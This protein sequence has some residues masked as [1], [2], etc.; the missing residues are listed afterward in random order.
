MP[1]SYPRIPYGMADFKAIRLQRRLYVDKT[2][3][4]RELENEDYVFLIRPRRF[5]KTYWL[6]LLE[7]YYDR[8]RADHFDNVFGGTDI[9]AR[10]TANRNRYVI[11]RFNFSAF[12]DAP[13]TLRERF[14]EHCGQVLYHA[15]GRNPDLFPEEAR[16][17][18]LAPPSI[19]GKLN[20]LFL[21]AGD[22]RIPLYV[23]I[24][25]YDNFA[26][27]VLAYHGE[28]SY[29]AF[30]HGGGFYRNFFAALKAGTEHSDGALERLFITGVSPIT[31]DDVTSGFNIG[32]NISLEPRFNELL[33]FT[34]REVRDLLDLHE[35]RESTRIGKSRWPGHPPP[36]RCVEGCYGAGSARGR[37]ACGG[38]PLGPLRALRQPVVS[39]RTAVSLRSLD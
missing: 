4:L 5:G 16:R 35:D 27:T 22:Q 11:L 36:C 34:E 12:D 31:L 8:N 24:D 26:N 6:S 20:R 18:I 7:H 38:R 10:P 13:E 33:G 14:E 32:S 21:Y 37:I 9:G 2:R 15:L 3:F 23:L 39:R 25:E 30:T 29:R 1:P 17:R 28:P 19:D